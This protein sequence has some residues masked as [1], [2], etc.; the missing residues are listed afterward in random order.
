MQHC[1]VYPCVRLAQKFG[2]H[3]K[4]QYGLVSNVSN[5]SVCLNKYKPLVVSGLMCLGL[6]V[7]NE[8]TYHVLDHCFGNREHQRFFAM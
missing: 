4:N 6:I 5:Y 1:H 3:T 8:Q 7:A 2:V